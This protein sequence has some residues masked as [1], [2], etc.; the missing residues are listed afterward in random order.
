MGI[1]W[2]EFLDNKVCKM[3]TALFLSMVTL[4]VEIPNCPL[5]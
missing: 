1:V 4:N 2:C 3:N 5:N